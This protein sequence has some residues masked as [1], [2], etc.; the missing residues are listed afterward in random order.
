M[1]SLFLIGHFYNWIY[2]GIVA[3]VWITSLIVQMC[4][5]ICIKK[6]KLA[7]SEF[8]D[9]RLKIVGDL[10]AGART[11]KCYGWEKKYI[12]DIEKTRNSQ[13]RELIKFNFL[14]HLGS[15]VYQNLGLL[16]IAIIFYIQW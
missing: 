4:S 2:S 10:V 7:D 13:T 1:V 8:S 14:A 15:A 6:F 9:K 12:E 3:G 5:S 16:C 11:I